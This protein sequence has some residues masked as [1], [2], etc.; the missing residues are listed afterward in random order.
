MWIPE[1]IRLLCTRLQSG[2]YTLV[3]AESLTGGLIG[4]ELTAIPGVSSVYW[5]GIIAYTIDAKQR[6]LAVDPVIIETCGVVSRETVE[7]M[8]RGALS[9]SPADIAVAVTGV[10]GP[11]GGTEAVPVGTVWIA[12]AKRKI[13][14]DKFPGDLIPEDF[15]VD[16][17][18]LHQSGSRRRVRSATVRAAAALACT[19]LDRD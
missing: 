10:A 13:P 17:L 3:T 16:S 19:C 8:A 6:L 7:A 12:V 11:G 5:G 15:I 1:P 14:G 2:G 4:A 9:V 18:C